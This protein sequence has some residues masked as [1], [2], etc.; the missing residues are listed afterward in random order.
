[1]HQAL[2]LGV[3]LIDTA[4]SYGNKGGSEEF[5]GATLGARR[6]DVV[7]AT[8]FGLPMK[9]PGTGGASRGYVMQAAEASLKRL[10]TD[11]ID[12][13]QVHR[14]DPKT[15]IEETLRALDDLVRQGKVRHIGCSNFSAEQIDEAQPTAHA[16]QAHAFIAA[17][18][19]TAC[20]RATSS[21]ELVPA[22]QEHGWACCR[23]S[24]SPAACS[25][26]S[27]SAAR[28]C[29]RT[30]G[31]PT[32]AVT[33][34]SSTS[35]TGR[36]SRSSMPLRRNPAIRCWNWRSAGCSASRWWRA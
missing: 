36:W 13:Y 7:L 32:A 18:T 20:W 14:P 8:K 23:I 6:K 19:N 30:R 2:D 12:L 24:R 9:E 10:R 34:N 33:A 11:W 1:M 28:R 35:A 21:S 25:P 17:R 27:T 22:M 16:A 29:R 3:T 31:S 5:L 15:P 4:D 26:A